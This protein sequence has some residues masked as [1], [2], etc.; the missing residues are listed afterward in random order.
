MRINVREEN[1]L[2]RMEQPGS[3]HQLAVFRILLGLQIL[4]SSSGL[5]FQFIQQ[6]PD[7]AKTSNIFPGFFNHWVDVIAIPVVQPLT[8]ILSIFLV[9]GLFT[10]YILPVLFTCFMLLFSFYYS[11]HNAPH[12]WI[13]IWF[14]LL[15]LNF[16]KSNDAFSL[17][18]VFRIVNPPTN[19]TSN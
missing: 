18:R 11:R 4:Y 14:P 13:Y 17:D 8:Q 7:T 5:I 1:I 3:V 12:P 2:A 19:P 16:T 9:A 10:R 6:V 15:I